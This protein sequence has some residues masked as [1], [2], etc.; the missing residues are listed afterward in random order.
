[1][2]TLRGLAA[3]P[4]VAIG[5]AWVIAPD[6]VALPDRPS[7]DAQAETSRLHAALE[8]VAEDLA[9]RAATATD[10]ET[11]AI[12]EAIAAMASDPELRRRADQL[13][14]RGTAAARAVV[15]AAD[16]FASV[17]AASGNDYL[18]ARAAD[19]SDVGR[20]AARRILGIV[21]PDLR[22]VPDGAIVVA[23]ELSPS[24]V[25]SLDLA[26]VRGVVT[27]GG[28]TTSHAAIVARANGLAA[29]VGVA[30][31]LA[32]LATGT[33]IALDGTSGEVIVDP[34]AATAGSFED[35]ADRERAERDRA[36]AAA[37]SGPATTADGVAIEVAANVAGAEELRAAVARG[38]QA[39]GLLRTELVYLDRRTPPTEAEQADLFRS[40]AALTPGRIV[41][42][43]FDFGADKPIPFLEVRAEANPALGVR[44]IRLAREHPDLL[45]AQ[46]RAV[47]AVARET[48]HPFAV[49]APMLSTV[50]EAVWFRSRVEAA[51]GGVEVGA[52]VEV[53]SAVL[54]ARDLATQLDFLSIGTNDLTQYLHAADREEPRLGAL[55]DPFD[56]AV[57]RA[58]GIV[59]DGARGRAWVGVCGEAAGD[60]TWAAVA[61]GLGVRE[62]SMSAA[63][64]PGVRAMLRATDLPA[65]E[66]AAVAARE[67]VDA[68]DARGRAATALGR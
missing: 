62:L 7:G 44:G 12:L 63:R 53:P 5:A 57:L 30:D 29:V 36:A 37:G 49:M 38:A 42:R 6:D 46:V 45:D 52:M 58:V 55:Q 2:R 14:D 22:A 61:V 64:I 27:E 48:G 41:V 21:G 60:P 33:Q 8:G 4:G 3:S 51:G 35:R 17:L 65:C 43:T 68:A 1:M 25:A 11:R 50:E 34:D 66:G 40:L 23:R 10:E 31:V 19:V 18:A 32:G 28:G 20:A 16:G 47:C 24:D 26:K 54:M 67:G 39:V 15:T 56:P 13:I 9:A 59:C